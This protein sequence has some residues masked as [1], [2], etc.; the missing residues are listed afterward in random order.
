MDSPSQLE[1]VECSMAIYAAA[2]LQGLRVGGRQQQGPL[3]Q[4][5]GHCCGSMMLGRWVSVGPGSQ[6]TPRTQAVWG[7]L[8]YN[9]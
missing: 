4:G 6:L 9:C 5:P 2:R 3:C 8:L 1:L 7:S